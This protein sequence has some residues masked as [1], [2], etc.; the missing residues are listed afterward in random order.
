MNLQPLGKKG[1]REFFDEKQPKSQEQQITII[2]Y[3][4]HRILEAETITTNHVF[5]GMKHLNLR[6]PSDLAQTMRTIASRKAYIDTSN[7]EDLKMAIAGDNFV[8]HDLP[9]TKATSSSE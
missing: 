4:L 9:A 8:E 2:V 1:L 3:Y 6:V 5:T 7:T